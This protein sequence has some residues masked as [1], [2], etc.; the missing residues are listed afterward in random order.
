MDRVEGAEKGPLFRLCSLGRGMSLSCDKARW[1]R[2]ETIRTSRNAGHVAA[3]PCYVL[4]ANSGYYFTASYSAAR[5]SPR[6]MF[7][8]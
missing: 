3:G 6:L 8:S 7:A 1:I 2:A 5:N 4:D